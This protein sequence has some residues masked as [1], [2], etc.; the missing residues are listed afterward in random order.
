MSAQPLRILQVLRAPIGGLYRHVADLSGA[1]AQRG[2]KLGLVMDSGLED[3]QTASRLEVL[4][5]HLPLGVHR[6]PISRLLGISDISTPLALHRLASELDIDIVH[7]HGAKGGFHARLARMAKSSPKAIYTPHGGALHFAPNSLQGRLFD[8]IERWLFGLTDG[9]AFESAYARD[10][11][12]ERIGTPP[13]PNPVVHN[14]LAQSEFDPVGTPDGAADF[15]FVGELRELKGVMHLLD[16]LV[17]VKMPD[18]RPANLV[19]AGD[20]ALRQDIEFRIEKEDLQGRVKLLGVQPA[21]D[22]F[23]KCRCV[24]VPSFAESLPYVVLEAAAAG[25]PVIATNVGGIP[26][27]FATST[28]DLI[29]PRDTHALA[30]AMQNFATSETAAMTQMLARQSYIAEH[31]SLEHM[32][33]GIEAL[34]RQALEP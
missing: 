11:Y 25:K 21:R 34:Y 14:G 23:A 33:D 5:A 9:V 18:G 24:V 13:C 26:E 7:G 8:S 4:N 27:I 15:G 28:A 20:G 12:L 17:D 1:L 3:P 31:F 6:L 10:V 30:V 16:A 2:H 32:T 19:M 22:V 29:P